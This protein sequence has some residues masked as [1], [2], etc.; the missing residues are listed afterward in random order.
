[1]AAG[2]ADRD[3]RTELERLRLENEA[4][5]AV[6]DL[7]A[8]SPD[9]DHVLGRVVDLLTRVSGSHATFVYLVAG[10][11]L[12]L[13]AA[14]PV[15]ARQVGRIEFGVDEGLA[16]WAVGHREAAFIRER[17][18]D[19]PRTNYIPELEEDRFQSMAAVPVPSRSGDVLG[20][21]VLHTAEPHEFDEGILN[22][23]SQTASVIAGAIENA[24]LYEESQQRVTDLTRLS[25]LSQ[26]IAAVTQRADLYR[27]ATTGVRELLPCDH[28]RLLELDPSGRLVVVASDPPDDG[29]PAGGETAEVLLEM[30]QSSPSE[31]LRLRGVAGRALAVPVA[32]GSEL[33]GALMVSAEQPWHDH[34]DELL[35]AIAHQ[36]AVALEK[37]ELIESLS[38]EGIARELF[39]ALQED[40]IDV[41]QARARKLGADL[42]RPHVVL[43]ARPL[44]LPAFADGADARLERSLRQAVPGTI[45]DADGRRVRALRPRR[46]HRRRWSRSSARSPASTAWRSASAP[47]AARRAETHS[48]LGEAADAAFVGVRLLED[49]GVLPYA[50]MG[51]YRYLVGPLRDGGPRDPLRE[52]VDRLAGL[53]PRAP[54]PAAADARALPRERPE[55]H[56]LGARAHGAR[57]HAAPAAGPDRVA[58]RTR[59]R[60]ARTCSRCSSRSSSPGS[61]ATRPLHGDRMPLPRSLAR[62]NLKVTNPVLSH[63][64]G[65]LPGFAILTH[66]GRRSGTT[67]SVPVNLFRD[68]DR[69]VIALTY[70]R[71]SQWV[72]NV[73]AAGGCEV[74]TRGRRVRLTDPEIVRDPEQRLVPAPV[75]VPLRFLGVEDFI[76]LRGG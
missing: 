20:V 53:R 60:R 45:C 49:G 54:R 67:Y 33:L 58:H 14:S 28:C 8:S 29:D 43:E 12:R 56:D 63:V 40:R 68:G 44:R 25:S 31:T 41:A 38:E 13:R 72:R 22:V 11:R 48:A 37:T 23:L 15:Y 50:D 6:V 71:E 47:S 66:V 57:Q 46:R 52:A 39:A 32:A 30:L 35:R 61:G 73:V 36:I 74:L 75:R 21:I 42:D 19:D 69:H 51:A 59:P 24:K 55:P 9:L 64:A 1:M 65:H 2:A 5:A 70:G 26:R 16:G 7:V 27:V 17:A 62:F 18:M 3:S 76:V 34:G 4:L 10:D